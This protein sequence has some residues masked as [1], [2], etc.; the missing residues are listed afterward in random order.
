VDAIEV[1]VVPQRQ[2]TRRGTAGHS[3]PGVPQGRGT[4]AMSA[5]GAR[6]RRGEAGPPVLPTYRVVAYALDDDTATVVMDATGVGPAVGMIDDGRMTGQLGRTGPMAPCEHVAI[7]IANSLQ[8]AEQT[9]MPRHAL[10][11]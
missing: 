9:N 7:L 2:Q 3:R 10:G 6:P 11:R 1:L 4:P 8:G 5:S